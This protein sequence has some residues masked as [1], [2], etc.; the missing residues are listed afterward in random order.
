MSVEEKSILELKSRLWKSLDEDIE[1]PEGHWSYDKCVSIRDSMDETINLRLDP[2]TIQNFTGFPNQENKT[3]RR[4]IEIIC[5]Y[6][7]VNCEQFSSFTHEHIGK[8]QKSNNLD[9]KKN[10]IWPYFR[11]FV[12]SINENEYSED[13]QQPEEIKPKTI[14]GLD[15]DK[16]IAKSQEEAI[17]FDVLLHIYSKFEK[18]QYPKILFISTFV[19]FICAIPIIWA[20]NTGVWTGI[21]YPLKSSY[22][23]WIGDAFL[24]IANVWIVLFYKKISIF[25]GFLVYTSKEKNEEVIKLFSS[26]WYLL[27]LILS[28]SI[29]A[30]MHYTFAK[31]DFHGWCEVSIGE[32]S[33]LGYYHL[34]IFAIQLFIFLSF[35]SYFYNI[36]KL[37]TALNASFEV[38]LENVGFYK[39]FFLRNFSKIINFYKIVI[40]F[41]AL[42]AISFLFTHHQFIKTHGSHIDTLTLWQKFQFG[43]FISLFFV[44][45]ISLYVLVLIKPIM[46]FMEDK[47]NDFVKQTTDI[48]KYSNSSYVMLMISN[49]PINPY[50]IQM[51][52]TML[53]RTLLVFLSVVIIFQCYDILKMLLAN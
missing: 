23:T 28:F 42:Y 13:P 25:L 32:L 10:K 27:L 8:K 47:R 53:I 11:K 48:N 52:K 49:L 51:Y 41:V 33:Y 19:F 17:K 43:L 16:E 31:D 1:M 21:Y 4:T 40:I 26:N 29:S 18:S 34:I 37:F 15:T 35:A 45:G 3:G 36:G 44:A 6:V 30:Y 22:T 50:K 24:C 38:S 20:I 14:E 7:Y 9:I 2:D 5:K 39:E 46:A 12:K